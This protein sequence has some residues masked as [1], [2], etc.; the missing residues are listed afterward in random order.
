[1]LT[2]LTVQTHNNN[3]VRPTEIFYE[4]IINYLQNQPLNGQCIER[5]I[6]APRL[7]I[8]KTYITKVVH[9]SLGSSS[10]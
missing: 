4:L 6:Y 3:K 7:I 10:R 1:M 8:S 2:V 5:I 9:K